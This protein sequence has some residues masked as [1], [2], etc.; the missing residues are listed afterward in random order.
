MS[1]LKTNQINNLAGKTIIS[2][3]GG[4]IVDSSF[5][6]MTQ[7]LLVYSDVSGNGNRIPGLALC[8]TPKKSTNIIVCEWMI[9]GETYNDNMF[10]VHKKVGSG[11]YALVT[12]TGYQSYNTTTGN[13]RY[14]GLNPGWYDPDFAST[15][16]TV[17]IQYHFVP[18]TTS[19][20]CLIP[21][22]R[23]AGPTAYNAYINR[24]TNSSGQTSYENSVSVGYAFE[25]ST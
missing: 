5:A 6:Y 4:N 17:N 19:N 13:V 24:S 18:N 2:N 21:A 12:D 11:D 7:Q 25:I 15:P 22:I 3:A 9:T 14:S 23:S 1:T 16:Q 10:L 8:I 20:V